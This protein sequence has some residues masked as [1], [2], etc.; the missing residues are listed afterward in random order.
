M[1]DTTNNNGGEGLTRLFAIIGL[2]V[3]ICLLAWLA[4]QVV[5]Y[6][7]TAFSSLASIFDA[8]QRELR[9]RTVG[10]QPVVVD[11]DEEEEDNDPVII[12]EEEEEDE[13]TGGSASPTDPTPTTPVKPTTPTTPP[14][15]QYQTVVTHTVPVSNPNGYTDLSVGFVAVG[16]MTN[17]D[18][19]LP[20]A[21]L[22]SRDR[23]AIQFKVTNIGSKTSGDWYFR[24]D[25][26]SGGS[27]NS[28]VQRPL[29][30]SE[31]AILT[32]A[33][34]VDNTRGNRVIEVR[35]TGGNDINFNNNTIRTNV[36]F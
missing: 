16:R 29:G 22:S 4:V 26:P 31:T 9:D 7:P 3:L 30:P 1:N 28:K 14:T 5:R 36:S 18:R 8:N 27:V 6:M 20:N 2:V 10:G 12:V 24:V 25:L 13:T 19:F 32:V 15:P 33:F 11:E 34:E 35:V 21:E 23:G 17:D